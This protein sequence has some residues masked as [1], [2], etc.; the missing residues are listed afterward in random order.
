MDIIIWIFLGFIL[1]VLTVGVLIKGI[2]QRTSE[3]SRELK[4]PNEVLNKR[5]ADLE[6][7]VEKLEREK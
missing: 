2:S 7:R 4:E 5:M 3:P 1:I 6:K